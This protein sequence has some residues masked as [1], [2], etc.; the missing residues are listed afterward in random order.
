MD[1]H[2]GYGTKWDHLW[3]ISIE[4]HIFSGYPF[5]RK[6]TYE[7]KRQGSNKMSRKRTKIERLRDKTSE[8]WAR[9]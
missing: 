2:S 6:I 3:P 4:L 5:V 7:P 1:L 9:F 8:T